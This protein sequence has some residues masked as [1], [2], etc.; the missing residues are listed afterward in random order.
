VPEPSSLRV[1]SGVFDETFVI[2]SSEP[3]EVPVEIVMIS[4]VSEDDSGVFA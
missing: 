2:V 4:S 3:G 1:I